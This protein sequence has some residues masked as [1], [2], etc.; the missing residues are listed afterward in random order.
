MPAFAALVAPAKFRDS[1]A[2]LAFWLAPGVALFCLGQFCLNPIA[3]LEG[4]TGGVL[5]AG[6]ATAGLDLGWMILAPPQDLAGYAWVHSVSLAAGFAL[7]LGLTARWRAYWPEARDLAGVALA[8]C[9]AVGAMSL[10]RNL[11]PALL[12]LLLT[13]A[14]GAG[15]FGLALLALDPG[16]LFR[17]VFARVLE[18]FQAKWPPVGVK[19]MRETRL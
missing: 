5:L 7:M 8:G 11:H 15:T 19:K 1:F 4:R 6:L 14:L 10:T 12:G 18:H 16:G 17:P 13:A 2:L 9:C 3:Q